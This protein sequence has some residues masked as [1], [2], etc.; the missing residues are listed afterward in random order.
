MRRTLCT[1]LAVGVVIFGA[2]TQGG[3]RAEAADPCSMLTTEAVAAALGLPEVKAS[4]G[5][6]RCIWLPKKSGTGPTKDVT[7][8][9][10]DAKGFDAQRKRFDVTPVT[11]VGDQAVQSTR[12]PVLTVQK[13][14]T[15]F[16][17]SVRGLPADQLR[18]T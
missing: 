16:A 11:G 4:P 7:L 14:S 15:Y 2:V 17:L 1:A 5:T 18:A 10:M 13:G 8:Q 9:L 3:L 6:N 12:I